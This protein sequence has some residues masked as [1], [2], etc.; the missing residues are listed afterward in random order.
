METIGIIYRIE[1]YCETV[2]KSS[3]NILTV[4]LREGDLYMPLET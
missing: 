3:W 4:K 2:K 1:F